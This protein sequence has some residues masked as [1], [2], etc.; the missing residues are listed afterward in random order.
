M[1]KYL[2]CCLTVFIN[3]AACAA[4]TFDTSYGQ[5]IMKISND[6]GINLGYIKA[7]S[8]DKFEISNSTIKVD[9]FS[10]WQNWDADVD[11]SN[12]ILQLNSA[13]GIENGVKLNHFSSATSGNVTI[14]DSSSLYKTRLEAHFDDIFLYLQK[15]TDDYQ[16]VF[17]N[18]DS[19]GGVI[20][21]I[22]DDNPDDKVL[23]A[24]NAAENETQIN[25][26]MN[27]SYHFNPL[28]LIR[29]IKT[30]NRAQIINL[31]LDSDGVGANVDYMMSG[32]TDNF[33]G[34]IY[35][36]DKYNDFYFN[37][38]INLNKFSY[39]DSLNEFDGFMYGIDLHAKQYLSNFWFDGLIGLNRTLLDADY[40]YKDANVS[41]D[42]KALSG[43]TRFGVGYDFIKITDFVISPFAGF[44]YQKSKIMN[45]SDTDFGALVGATA[46]YNFV[47]DGIKYE[48]GLSMT[49]DEKLNW[50]VGGDI[51]FTSV[52]DNIGA[53]MGIDIFKD[54][55]D[56]INYKLSANAKIQF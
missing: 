47:M 4:I 48:Y 2:L 7:Q 22:R 46:K 44:V 26:I 18:S 20:E 31:S 5:N 38:K 16:K 36:G 8:A 49:S 23:A 28:I 10:D 29:P 24:M 11:L 3:Y 1:N 15:V 55:F 42:P 25:S 35:F 40:I 9:N 30:I 53:S 12:V 39:K 17:D 19:R 34:H 52:I 45:M 51:G 43:Y 6:T 41:H 14:K 37:I 13:D 54:E 50:H 21:S 32:K 27:S 33:A 56:N